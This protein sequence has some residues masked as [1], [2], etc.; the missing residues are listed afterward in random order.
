LSGREYTPRVSA[1]SL[2]KI[3]VEEYWHALL[4][5]A[6][7]TALFTHVISHSL[8]MLLNALVCDGLAPAGALLQAVVA[9]IQA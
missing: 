9:G 7:L 3:F 5:V 4:A 2:V 6:L 1:L 8:D